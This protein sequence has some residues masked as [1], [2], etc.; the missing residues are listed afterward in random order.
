MTSG[1]RADELHASALDG[2]HSTEAYED[3]KRLYLDT[4]AQ[5]SSQGLQFI[6]LV[7]EAHAVEMSDLPQAI[8]PLG[9]QPVDNKAAVSRIDK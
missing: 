1:L 7:V 5:C 3:V 6:P 4:A 2:S 9:R 8:D